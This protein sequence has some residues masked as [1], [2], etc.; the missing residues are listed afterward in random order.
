MN[1]KKFYEKNKLI[2]LFFIILTQSLN[3]IYLESN[4]MSK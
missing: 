4:F 1:I 3:G 2:S